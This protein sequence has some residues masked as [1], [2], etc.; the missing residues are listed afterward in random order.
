MAIGGIE[1]IVLVTL[2]TK[3]QTGRTGLVVHL[4]RD[5]HLAGAIG[6]RRF[7]QT[8]RAPAESLALPLNTT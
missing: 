4:H 5:C 8:Q 2:G 3:R 6:H 7:R 1:A